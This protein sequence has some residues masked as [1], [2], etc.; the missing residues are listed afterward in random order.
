MT[1]VE[2]VNLGCPSGASRKLCLTAMAVFRES[3]IRTGSPFVRRQILV[4]PIPP[5]VLPGLPFGG[6]KLPADR[7]R[8]GPVVFGKGAVPHRGRF[9]QRCSQRIAGPNVAHV[10]AAPLALEDVVHHPV[11]NDATP[12]RLL[13]VNALIGSVRSSVG[14]LAHRA[15]ADRAETDC[16]NA[17]G[18][19]R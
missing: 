14:S 9:G 10:L 15:T 2:M 19:G 6:P 8:F 11:G 13:G 17:E 18:R 4:I 5:F 16:E 12:K 1:V 7:D 3:Q